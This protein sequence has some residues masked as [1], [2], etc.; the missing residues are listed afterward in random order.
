MLFTVYI[1]SVFDMFRHFIKFSK[2]QMTNYKAHKR[3][4]KKNLVGV[5]KILLII[6][7]EKIIN[8]FLPVVSFFRVSIIQ[9][10]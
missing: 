10:R 2:V 4:S 6:F 1:Y 7:T 8:H 3:P 9:K 5:R